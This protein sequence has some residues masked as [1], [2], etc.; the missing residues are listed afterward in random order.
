MLHIKQITPSN[1]VITPITAVICLLYTA[2][3]HHHHHLLNWPLKCKQTQWVR[4]TKKTRRI[5]YHYYLEQFSDRIPLLCSPGA[6]LNLID[7]QHRRQ[8]RTLNMAHHTRIKLNL[9]TFIHTNIKYQQIGKERKCTQRERIK[10]YCIRHDLYFASR[11]F[12]ACISRYLVPGLA[13]L[14]PRHLS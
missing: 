3:R 13:Y 11:C 6:G 1:Q 2:P 14:V 12:W 10:N 4:A 9:K 7:Q 8:N 5:L